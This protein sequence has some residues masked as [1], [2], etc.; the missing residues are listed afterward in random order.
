MAAVR[1]NVKHA[2][3]DGAISGVAAHIAAISAK[4]RNVT[5]FF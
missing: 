3:S 5:A 4:S 2:R 1:R